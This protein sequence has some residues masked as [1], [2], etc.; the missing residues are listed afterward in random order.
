MP[1]SHVI[2]I[3]LPGEGGSVK[4]L[5]QKQE[6]MFRDGSAAQLHDVLLNDEPARCLRA[7]QFSDHWQV[8]DLRHMAKSLSITAGYMPRRMVMGVVF[9]TLRMAYDT[10][11]E[12]Q[13]QVDA[14]LAEAT[15]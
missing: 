7:V 2:Q 4:V 9:Q 8:F 6:V 13:E 11:G 10:V 15:P 5:Q 12:F 1:E 14:S 3:M